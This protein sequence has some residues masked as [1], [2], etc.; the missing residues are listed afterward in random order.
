MAAIDRD[1]LPVGGRS[2]WLLAAEAGAPESEN[3]EQAAALVLARSWDAVKCRYCNERGVIRV[4]IKRGGGVERYMTCYSHR[5]HPLAHGGGGNQ[6]CTYRAIGQVG[7]VL[8][9]MA[10]L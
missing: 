4:E 6:T 2:G 10:G 5:P 1:C 8:R 7:I 3:R 9:R